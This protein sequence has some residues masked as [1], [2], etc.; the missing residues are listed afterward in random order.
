MPPVST[1]CRRFGGWHAALHEIGET[2]VQPPVR[3]YTDA[4]LIDALATWLRDGGDSKAGTYHRDAARLGLPSFNTIYQRL[5]SWRA[6][7]NLASS[8]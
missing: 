3:R 6:A 4:E 5:G 1:I 2:T 7:M 8:T